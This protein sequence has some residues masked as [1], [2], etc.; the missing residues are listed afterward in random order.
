MQSKM[1]AK[2]TDAN[3]VRG[4]NKSNFQANIPNKV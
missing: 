4:S 2:V 3:A 1:Q